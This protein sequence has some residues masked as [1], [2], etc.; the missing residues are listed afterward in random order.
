[1]VSSIFRIFSPEVF[2]GLTA[3]A[4]GIPLSEVLCAEEHNPRQSRPRIVKIFMS[5]FIG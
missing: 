2:A 3:M 5:G 4:P 1:M